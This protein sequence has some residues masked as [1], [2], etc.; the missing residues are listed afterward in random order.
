MNSL[1]IDAAVNKMSG[2][3]G[4]DWGWDSTMFRTTQNP[5]GER[6]IVVQEELRDMYDEA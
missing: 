5:L 4:I 3:L 6:L 1:N 2:Q